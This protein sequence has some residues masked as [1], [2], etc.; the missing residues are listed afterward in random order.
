MFLH[1]LSLRV[2]PPRTLGITAF[3]GYLSADLCDLGARVPGRTQ[4]GSLQ[5]LGRRSKDSGASARVRPD[6]SAQRTLTVSLLSASLAS[7]GLGWPLTTHSGSPFLPWLLAPA[8]QPPPQPR[9]DASNARAGREEGMPGSGMHRGGEERLGRAG[10]GGE[11]RGAGEGVRE[12]A[13]PAKDACARPPALEEGPKGQEC[14]V[15]N[16][17]REGAQ[18]RRFAKCQGQTGRGGGRRLAGDQE[19]RE[20]PTSPSKGRFG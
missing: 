11:P 3:L 16:A 8:R 4:A 10:A 12:R 9:P 5:R 1:P 7:H 18:N 6:R 14:N 20:E 17:H 2:S 19:Q 15:E 13:P